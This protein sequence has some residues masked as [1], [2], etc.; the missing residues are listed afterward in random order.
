MNLCA[1]SPD[2][3]IGGT[4]D[5]RGSEGMTTLQMCFPYTCQPSASSHGLLNTLGGM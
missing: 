2:I 4:F 5:F 3:V 1:Q